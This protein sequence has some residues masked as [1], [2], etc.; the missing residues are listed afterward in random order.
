MPRSSYKGSSTSGNRRGTLG[1]FCVNGHC[2]F[3]GLFAHHVTHGDIE[4]FG[5][6]KDLVQVPAARADFL[7]AEATLRQSKT[8]PQLTLRHVVD[9]HQV[10]QAQRNLLVWRIRR[11]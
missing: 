11:L 7:L 2:C 1:G 10:I 5:E 8:Q 9:I 4:D 6:A 3:E